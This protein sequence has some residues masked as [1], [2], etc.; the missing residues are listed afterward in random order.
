MK[1]KLS[2]GEARAVW[3]LL[4]TFWVLN[5]CQE[6]IMFIG[7][8]IPV[9]HN[10]LYLYLKISLETQDISSSISVY[11]YTKYGKRLNNLLLSIWKWIYCVSVRESSFL[12]LINL[13]N[14]SRKL[15]HILQDHITHLTSWG[16]KYTASLRKIN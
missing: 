8:G 10:N 9:W 5:K 13:H 16:N 15:Q 12:E 2:L 7:K 14:K 6:P 11:V 1:G 4:Q 3:G